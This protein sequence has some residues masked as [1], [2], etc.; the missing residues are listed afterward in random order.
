[1]AATKFAVLCQEAADGSIGAYVPDL[2]GCFSVGATR[3]EA[4]QQIRDA[5]ELYVGDRRASGDPVPTP[6][7]IVG[8]VDAE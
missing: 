7:T 4:E 2:P 6:K 8:Y 5:L 1:M 3:D